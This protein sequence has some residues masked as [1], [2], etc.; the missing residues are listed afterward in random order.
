MQL[1]FIEKNAEGLPFHIA[2]AEGKTV[3]EGIASLRAAFNTPGVNLVVWNDAADLIAPE[4]RETIARFSAG[5]ACAASIS[6]N[7]GISSTFSKLAAHLWRDDQRAAFAAWEKTTLDIRR[8]LEQSYGAAETMLSLVRFVR[9]GK[10]AGFHVDTGYDREITMLRTVA[11]DS[12]VFAAEK[13]ALIDKDP[14]AFNNISLNPRTQALWRVRPWS[15]C[16]LAARSFEQAPVHSAPFA[17]LPGASGGPR[18]LELNVFRTKT[19]IVPPRLPHQ[20]RRLP[21]KAP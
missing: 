16:F 20:P 6:G 21:R 10:T 18:T 11:G 3:R 1:R 2:V 14:P 12:T 9:P 8:T 4:H 7:D 17:G 13:D 19:P 5:P 15:I